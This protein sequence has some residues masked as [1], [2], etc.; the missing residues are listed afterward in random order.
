M[1]IVDLTSWPGYCTENDLLTGVDVSIPDTISKAQ[2]VRDA[3]D[4]IDSMI[5]FLYTT[6]VVLSA[7]DEAK[8]RPTVLLLKRVNRFLASGRLLL[9][10]AAVGEDSQLHAYGKSLV[11]DA[12]AVLAAIVDRKIILEGVLPSAQ[13][14]D[15]YQVSRGY[16]FNLDQKSGVETFYDSIVN[17]DP[18]LD[19]SPWHGPDL[20]NP[21][22]S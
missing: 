13:Q 3:A 8:Y 11:D 22:N 7:T 6:P 15:T 9:A 1:A 12:M 20:T 18:N 10:A 21:D 2:F 5:G 14:A 19:R 16:I 17:A 4:E